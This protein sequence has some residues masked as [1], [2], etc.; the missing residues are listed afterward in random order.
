M[1][2][3]DPKKVFLVECHG[4]QRALHEPRDKFF[5]SCDDFFCGSRYK[6]FEARI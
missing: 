3:R 1:M 6:F 4:C 2:S 5:M